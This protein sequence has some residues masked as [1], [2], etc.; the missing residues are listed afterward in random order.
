MINSQHS[1]AMIGE[2]RYA[3]GKEPSMIAPGD[4]PI[5]IAP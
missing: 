4:R 1:C 3:T 5:T 2:A